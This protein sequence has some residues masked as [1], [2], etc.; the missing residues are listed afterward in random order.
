M[1]IRLAHPRHRF[2]LSAML[3][4]TQ[5][6]ANTTAGA[7]DISLA[8]TQAN[9]FGL[10]K[11]C[12][13]KGFVSYAAIELKAKIVDLVGAADQKAADAAR[14]KGEHG[15]R[16]IMGIDQSMAE[17]S[18]DY[19]RAMCQSQADFDRTIATTYGISR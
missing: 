12:K 13:A 8:L 19:T 4:A 1:E 11:F 10:L 15:I 6:F 18:D 2:A 16:S 3:L 17:L 9:E 7:E 5:L 14:E